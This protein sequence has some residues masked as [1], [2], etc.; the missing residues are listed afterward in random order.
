MVNART[1]R[2][3]SG[4]TTVHYDDQ[5]FTMQRRGGISRYFVELIKEFADPGLRIRVHRGWRW[6]INQHAIEAGLGAPLR[7]P[8]GSRGAVLRAANG[9]LAADSD[10]DVEHPTY[11]RREYVT[12]RSKKPMVVTVYDMTPELYPELFRRGNP[13][14]AKREFV[15]RANLVVCISESTRRDL[16]RVYG[17]VAAP[18]VVT[19]LGVSPRFRA[20]VERPSWCP[21]RF[22]LFVGNR[23]GY[24]DFRVA[25]DAFAEL[26]PR[27]PGMALLAV[28][29][30]SF[31]AD[32][33]AV[34][35]RLRLARR[36]I[37]RGA[38]DDDLP[39]V[40]NGATAFIFPSR[41]EGF[42][43]P[44]LEA[45]ACGTPA[46]VADSSSHPEAGGDAALYF[47]PGD[48]S[49]L[50]RQLERLLDDDATREEAST[51]GLAHASQFTWRRTALATASAYH[52]AARQV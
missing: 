36:V 13:H 17:S 5:V 27:H 21:D 18:T 12:R 34:I 32:E 23:A 42:G 52:E 16:L 43:L 41:Y 48:S 7:L 19:H 26:A 11:Y 25:L 28:G 40:F 1:E 20:G 2:T 44:T 29:G 10:V 6:T 33:N 3:N 37:Q 14:A 15:E 45:L 4:R 51:K 30:G 22:F 8:G 31:S 35:S 39:G 38:S 47:P 24:K 49:S 50:A 9:L 46:V